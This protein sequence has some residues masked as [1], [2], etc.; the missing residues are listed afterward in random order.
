MMNNA[1][2]SAGKFFVLHLTILLF[3]CAGIFSKLAATNEFLSGRFILFYGMSLA[4]MFV[5]AILWQQVLKR[6]LLSTAY[7]NCSVSVVWGILWGVLFFEETLKVTTILGA[8]IVLAG[9]L[10]VVSK[11][12]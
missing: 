3:S 9:V 10:L 11:N 6:M 12:E 4:V 2:S 1:K 5:Y 7:I 8:V